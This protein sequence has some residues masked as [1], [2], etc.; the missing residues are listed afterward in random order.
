MKNATA[1]IFAVV[2]ISRQMKS[3]SL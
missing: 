2:L 3:P 1:K